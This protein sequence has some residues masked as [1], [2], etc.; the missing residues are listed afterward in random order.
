[1]TC[2]LAP[3]LHCTPVT[4]FLQC[5]LVSCTCGLYCE[6]EFCQQCTSETYLHTW[7]LPLSLE[8]TVRVWSSSG[9]N[10]IVISK[11]KC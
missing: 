1:M 5:S 6:A 3:L 9:Q 7:L 8:F 11:M 2:D 10:C 4:Y